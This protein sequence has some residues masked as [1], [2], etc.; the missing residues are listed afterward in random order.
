MNQKLEI[1]LLKK[2][3]AIEKNF[4]KIYSRCEKISFLKIKKELLLSN[5]KKKIV[6]IW[7][8]IKS[9][10]KA[11]RLLINKHKLPYF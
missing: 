1:S 6:K 8:E 11:L 9:N 7:P 10:F 5:E 2:I 3:K 4:D